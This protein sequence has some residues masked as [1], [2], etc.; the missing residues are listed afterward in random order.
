MVLLSC[1]LAVDAVICRGGAQQAGW[2][3]ELLLPPRVIAG[4]GGPAEDTGG[5]P[6]A[7]SL[8]SS[9]WK[10]SQCRGLVR[11]RTVL[12]ELGRVEAIV[13]IYGCQTKLVTVLEIRQPLL[14]LYRSGWLPVGTSW[15]EPG[16][17]VIWSQLCNRP[18]C[19]PELGR[20]SDGQFMAAESALPPHRVENPVERSQAPAVGTAKATNQEGEHLPLVTP[21]DDKLADGMQWHG[22]ALYSWR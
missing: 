21:F 6:F 4:A 22:C 13:R 20:L 3:G 2:L 14:V 17:D 1:V 9:T 18:G 5:A 8:A 11:H 7:Y 19:C 12:Y 16:C 10:G 15:N